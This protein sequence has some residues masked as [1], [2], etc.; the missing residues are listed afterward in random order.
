[1]GPEEFLPK[2]STETRCIINN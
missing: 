2:D 1:M